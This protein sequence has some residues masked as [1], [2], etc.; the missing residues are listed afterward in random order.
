MG[1]PNA[2]RVAFSSTI[3]RFAKRVAAQI[4]EQ[5]K[6]TSSFGHQSPA[7][8]Q[9]MVNIGIAFAGIGANVVTGMV[10]YGI[11]NPDASLISL[12]SERIAERIAVVFSQTMMQNSSIRRLSHA[13]RSAL[14]T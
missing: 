11:A 1:I 10:I 14:E 2:E 6:P 7:N 8:R 9:H 3:S 13:R 5:M 12:V 4:D